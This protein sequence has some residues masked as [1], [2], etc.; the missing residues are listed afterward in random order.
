M[1][2][3]VKSSSGAGCMVLFSLPFAGVGIFMTYL[4]LSTLWAGYAMQSWEGV[5][6]RIVHTELV[7]LDGDD[8]TTYKVE[9]RYE[10][11]YE[12]KTYTG[13]RVAISS[14]ADNIG[15]YQ[16]D[17]HNELQRHQ[18]SEEPFRCYINPDDPA[19]SVLY[20]D[21][22]WFMLML[23]G[24]FIVAFGGFGFGMMFFSIKGGKAAK[25]EEEQKIRHPETPWLWNG[26]WAQGRIRSSTKLKAIGV[27][28]FAT[29]WNAIS[30]PIAILAMG[31][32]AVNPAVYAVLL[33]PLVGLITA[34][35]AARTL[36]AWYKYGESVLAMAS[37]PG[38]IGGA[39]RGVV[40]TNV[41]LRPEEG[42]HLT[43]S[44]INRRTS[45]SG[46]SRTTHEHVL[47]QDARVMK[48]EILEQDPT[49]SHIPVLFAIPYDARASDD[50]D[51]NNQIIWRLEA[52]AKVPGADYTAQF[53]VPVFKT[54]E[55]SPDFVLDES[56]LTPYQAPGTSRPGL[57]MSGVRVTPLASG[58]K[59]F[60]LPMA[61]HK[62][63]ALGVTLFLAIWT[64]AIVF[65]LKAG[66]PILFPIVFSLFEVLTLY[67]ALDLW[68]YKSR[69]E[70]NFQVLTLA[71]SI[72]GIGS[73]HTLYYE[74]IQDISVTRG[75]QVGNKLYYGV[76]V[77]MNN[78]K[79]H[80]AAKRLDN[81]QQ[82]E[83][84][85]KEIEKALSGA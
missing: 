41:N 59:R 46:K 28:A 61:R 29:L 25:A 4:L 50:E 68:F 67:L 33:F 30:W 60:V 64:G 57:E 14:S 3:S 76:K 1:A 9:A 2:K 12:D 63:A 49:Q 15:T 85:A 17:I 55:S 75:M 77:K 32:R 72:L 71:G 80:T 73:T 79:S 78:G 66:A 82:A 42:F 5:P 51:S 22:R 20:R 19:D 7:E 52:T 62:S 81:R 36:I 53:E 74:Q 47:W 65:M 10:Y 70:V 54:A 56:A 84:L 23:Y 13:T 40:Q 18:E 38:V 26:D 21:I 37:V 6:A 44:C 48:R 27:C 11:T 39:L 83:Q 34:A 69:I 8:S 16:H 45:G 24:V 43:L 35:A 31:E 58:G